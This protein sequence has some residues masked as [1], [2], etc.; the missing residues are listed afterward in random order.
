MAEIK[1]VFQVDGKPFFPLGGQ[2]KN[3]SGYNRAEAETAFRAVKALHGNTL[4]IPVYWE[5]V[6]PEEGAFDFSSVDTLLGSCR[7]HDLRLIVLWFATWKNGEMRYCP[8]WVKSD[9][10]RFQR[11]LTAPDWVFDT[12]HN[13]EALLAV[14]NG[15]LLALADDQGSAVA[16]KAG[17]PRAQRAAEAQAAAG[18]VLLP[19][20]GGRLRLLRAAQGDLALRGPAVER[21]QAGAV[22]LPTAGGGGPG[23][24][25]G[26]G[27]QQ[28][29]QQGSGQ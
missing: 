2:A 18:T 5:Q 23:L 10:E 29:R 7:E 4:E 19:A 16:V 15:R 17:G 20:H 6:E 11:V 14:G 8:G 3:S 21:Q 13:T 12:A 26:A 9:R 27:R 24:L 25:P 28:Q 1:R 22:L